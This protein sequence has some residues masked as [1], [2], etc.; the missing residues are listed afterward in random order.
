[1]SV[2]LESYQLPSPESGVPVEVELYQDVEDQQIQFIESQWMPILKERQNRAIL[3]VK[4]KS[5]AD[6][7]ERRRIFNKAQANV[8][9]Q[10][11]HWNWRDKIKAGTEGEHVS[12]FISFGSSIEAIMDCRLLH[13]AREPSQ[14]SQPTIYVNH[15]AVAPWNRSQIQNPRRIEKLGDLMM[16]TAVSMSVEEGFGGRVGLHS[17]EGAE[18]FYKRCGMSDLGPDEHYGGLRYFE[19]TDTQAVSFITHT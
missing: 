8:G 13:F 6:D 11:G 19:F 5:I 14:K 4:S 17:L 7:D 1:M 16:A 15:V 3:E 18:G 2:L 12:F 9:A 10:D